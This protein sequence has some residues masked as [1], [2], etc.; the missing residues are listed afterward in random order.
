MRRMRWG[1][2]APIF[3]KV[4]I[5]P[6]ECCSG[7][8][9]F[10]ISCINLDG[11]GQDIEGQKKLKKPWIFC[12]TNIPGN[13]IISGLRDERHSGS[14]ANSTKFYLKICKKHLDSWG[15]LCYYVTVRESGHLY[16]VN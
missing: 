16:L 1:K 8:K 5:L 13:A 9:N 7:G 12:L 10:P 3:C 15:Y 11:K 4:D 14:A 6:S 2:S